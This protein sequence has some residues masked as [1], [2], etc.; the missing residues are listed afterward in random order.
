[1]AKRSQRLK[2]Y[3]TPMLAKSRPPDQTFIP[4]GRLRNIFIAS[5]DQYSAL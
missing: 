3:P 1:M 5:F 2:K 4:F